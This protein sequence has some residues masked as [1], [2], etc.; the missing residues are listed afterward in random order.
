MTEH[1]TPGWRL[2]QQLHE[3]QTSEEQDVIAASKEVTL[4]AASPTRREG[5][6]H[7]PLRDSSQPWL[8]G[9]WSPGTS[10]AQLS[11]SQNHP[12]L[13]EQLR[14]DHQRFGKWPQGWLWASSTNR[15]ACGSALTRW[16]KAKPHTA[17][18]M[19][20]IYSNLVSP[21]QSPFSPPQ[22]PKQGS[23]PPASTNTHTVPGWTSLAAVLPALQCPGRAKTVSRVL[24]QNIFLLRK[25]QLCSQQ[26]REG[27][28]PLGCIQQF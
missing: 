22:S 16:E 12:Q 9:L 19:L 7:S 25:H 15:A 20:L 27:K 28:C 14:G 13:L 11:A 24:T 26:R 8:M 6:S 2:L 23:L 18:Q 3:N 5:T 1:Q 4:P 10:L 17:L 21:P